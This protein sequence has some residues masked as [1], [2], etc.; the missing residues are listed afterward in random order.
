[1]RVLYV[2]GNLNDYHV[3]RYQ[4]LAHLAAQNGVE[5][6]LIEIYGA[7][8]LYGFP[9]DHREHFFNGGPKHCMTLFPDAVEGDVSWPR[10]CARLSPIVRS[11]APDCVVTLGYHTSY[12]LWLCLLKHFTRDYELIYMSDSKA[13][14]GKRFA[15][16]E[17]AK[18]MLVSCFDGAFVAGEKHRAYAES[19]GVPL[20]RS[21]VGYDV[22]DVAYIRDAARQ[23]REQASSVRA[24]HGLPLRYALCVS[25]F[26]PKKNVDL[27]VRAYAASELAASGVALVLIGQGPCEETLR[28]EIARL[29]LTSHVTILHAVPNRD[30][31]GIYGLA[32]FVVLASEFDQWGLCIN[33]ALAAGRP[34]IVTRTCGVAD[35]LVRENVNG[36]IIEPGDVTSLAERM[37][38]LGRTESLRER[39]AA[40]AFSMVR[41]WTPE[42]FAHNLL[43]LI[44]SLTAPLPA[45]SHQTGR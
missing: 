23:A 9:Q 26:V 33:E 42:R 13:D 4:A 43:E 11:T 24:A 38:L 44:E 19:L 31:P 36:F 2:I 39:F 40:R 15:L 6:S 5:L 27:V 14:D 10:I 28:K 41:D 25:R 45:Q 32:D 35:E 30:M 20:T 34:V 29:E 22:I 21:R 37:Q 12:S 1:M 8:G 3:P 17:R 16:K 18:R 7:S